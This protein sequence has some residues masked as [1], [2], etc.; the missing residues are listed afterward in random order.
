MQNL[1]L[2]FTCHSSLSSTIP[3]VIFFFFLN[4]L[5]LDG[6]H[7]LLLSVSVRL[8]FF[9]CRQPVEV[10]QLWRRHRESN[11]ERRE[12]LGLELDLECNK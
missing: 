4:V 1:Y 7:R 6:Y 5:D 8:F 10:E 2:F 12:S 9:S 3:S 11:V